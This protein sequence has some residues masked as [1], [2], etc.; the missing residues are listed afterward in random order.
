MPL[1][2]GEAH[3]DIVK[4]WAAGYKAGR[5]SGGLDPPPDALKPYVD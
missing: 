1:A 4:P 5:D 2:I 3:R